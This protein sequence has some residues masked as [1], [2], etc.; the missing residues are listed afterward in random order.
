M[1]VE[2][3]LEKFGHKYGYLYYLRKPDAPKYETVEEYYDDTIDHWLTLWDR[4]PM[5]LPYYM[6]GHKSTEDF[7]SAASEYAKKIA[8]RRYDLERD[9]VY[10]YDN[11][12]VNKEDAPE[13]IKMVEASPDFLN[14]I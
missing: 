11:V 10:I 6:R 9:I 14:W 8:Q 5:M 13:I 4:D 7:I 2:S 12:V 1:S 3:Q